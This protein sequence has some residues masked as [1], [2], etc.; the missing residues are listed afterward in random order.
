[1]AA[2]QLAG[3]IVAIA[4]PCQ[5]AFKNRMSVEF[6]EAVP[7]VFGTVSGAAPTAQQALAPEGGVRKAVGDARP[8]GS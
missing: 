5:A 6:G 8:R 7:G 2:R 1:M 4:V 3:L